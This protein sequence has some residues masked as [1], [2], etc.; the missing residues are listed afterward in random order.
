MNKYI[1]ESFCKILNELEKINNN[2]NKI[3]TIIEKPQQ[4]LLLEDKKKSQKEKDTFKKDNLLYS[5][6][7]LDYKIDLDE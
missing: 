5:A 6:A 3:I 7:D 1:K 4:R 2:L